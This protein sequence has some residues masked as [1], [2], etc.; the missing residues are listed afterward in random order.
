MAGRPRMK[1]VAAAAGVSVMTVSRV[2]N[3][4][5]GVAP[6]TAARVEAAVRKLGYQRDDV[7]RQLRRTD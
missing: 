6:R 7:A 2:V 1:D 5:A 4:E 3:G